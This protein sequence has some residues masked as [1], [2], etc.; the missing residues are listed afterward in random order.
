[1]DSSA[2]LAL[3]YK[4]DQHHKKAVAK[5]SE[6]K[7]RKIGMITSEYV[8]DE[9]LTLIRHRTSHHAAVVFGEA[10]FNS[11]IV[12]VEEVKEDDR[13]K[14]WDIFKK[15]HDKKLSFTDCTSF[16]LMQRMRLLK[17]FTFDKHF[18]QM[19]IEVI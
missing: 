11:N 16:A 5:S 6:I 7:K 13:R 17:A 4:N 18:R 10:V 15:Y 1:M 14:A 9:T 19:G 2:W 8:I 12:R 3:D